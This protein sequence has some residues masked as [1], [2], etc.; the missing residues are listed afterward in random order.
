MSIFINGIKVGSLENYILIHVKFSVF[1]C[2]NTKF[3]QTKKY[4]LV[5]FQSNHV[6][7]ESID[8]VF[9]IQILFNTETHEKTCW[10]IFYPAISISIQCGSAASLMGKR[11]S[12]DD[13]TDA[14]K[15][16]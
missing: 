10:F 4:T 9:L 1:L 16:F 5:V 12:S 15:K 14:N 8:R 13:I 11:L 7:V 2:T 6:S 3:R